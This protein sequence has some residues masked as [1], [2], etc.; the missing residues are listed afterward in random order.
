MSTGV[1]YNADSSISLY[2]DGKIQ[3]TVNLGD[4]P[5]T[6]TALSTDPI[7]GIGLGTSNDHIEYLTKDPLSNIGTLI[8]AHTLSIYHDIDKK[9]LLI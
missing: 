8:N 5:A 9:L 6:I 1:V 4:Y 7:V 3:T 2:K